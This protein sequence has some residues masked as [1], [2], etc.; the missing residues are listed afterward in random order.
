MTVLDSQT[1]RTINNLGL[2]AKKTK[3]GCRA[4]KNKQRTIRSII[5]TRKSNPEYQAISPADDRAGSL[6][7]GPF[8]SVS[9]SMHDNLIDVHQ[10]KNTRKYKRIPVKTRLASWNTR[11]M[12]NKVTV[13]CDIIVQD[14]LDVLAVQETWLSGNEKDNCALAEIART[15]PHFDF[16]QSPRISSRGG[17]VCVLAKKGFKMSTNKT[18]DYPSFE[19]MDINISRGS[20]TIRLFNIYRPPPSQKNKLTK[21]MFLDDFSKFLESTISIPCEILILGDFNVHFDV[22]DDR[23]ASAFRDL[24]DT[25]GLRQGV[26]EKTHKSGHILDLMI[27]RH[28]SNTI[29]G[30]V[31]VHPGTPS[32]H[33]A[34][35]CRLNLFPPRA[36]RKTIQYRKI[37]Q[38]VVDDFKRDIESSSVIANPSACDLDS[39][40]DQFNAVLQDLL[41]KHAPLVEKTVTVRHNTPWYNDELRSAKQEK[42]RAERKYM[43]S[44]LEVHKQIYADKC[45]HYKTMLES[46]KENHHRK[47][48]QESS[49]KEL[50]RAVKNLC[51]P[52]SEPVLPDCTSQKQL[53]EK[54]ATFFDEK[55]INIRTVIDSSETQN[56]PISGNTTC[57]TKFD[58]FRALSQEAVR[59]M[60]MKSPSKSCPL[61]PIPTDLFK[62]CVD[63]LLPAVTTIVNQSLSSGYIPSSLKSARVTPLLKKANSD[64]NVY[65]NYRPVSQLPFLGKLLERCCLSQ[66]QEHFIDNNL[67]PDAQSAYRSN[68]STETALLC[69]K[70]DILRGLDQNQEAAL[71]LL[72]LSA[73]FDT[74]DHQILLERLEKRYGIRSTALSWF[75]SYLS[76]RTQSVVIGGSVSNPRELVYG[77]P[78]G[79]VMGA[80]LFT[81]YSAPI[82]D[83]IKSHNINHIMY[84]DDTQ[85][86]LLFHPSE[87]E[88][89][90]NKIEKC[91][92]DI[93]TWAV[94]NKLQFND[95]K[96]EVLH[97]TSRF[98]D[99]DK[100][101]AV[102]IGNTDVTV[103]SK[104]RN[105]G[106]VFDEHLT[107]NDHISSVLRSGWACIYMLG[108]IR[109]YLDRAC[110]ERL[111]H[112]FITSRI[113][114]CNSLLSDLPSNQI[115]R[116]QRLQN[117]AARLIM[118]RK[119]RDHIT[120]ILADLH[121]LPVCQR[122]K[123]K[124]L[125]LVFKC[126]HGLGPSYLTCLIKPYIPTRTLRSSSKHLL[127]LPSVRPRTVTY[128]ARAFALYG[129]RLWNDL[130]MNI[131]STSSL[132]VFKNSLKT[133]LFS[134]YYIQLS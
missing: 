128:G 90:I 120:P 119:R 20:S 29:S 22:A 52:S 88:A 54:F 118:L 124:I 106:V 81:F 41:D 47:Q 109:R 26:T 19:Y 134:Q 3:R 7:F 103:C 37:R 4:G 17:G 91:I 66:V 39:L 44:Q 48:I 97:I 87:R 2:C 107:F 14:K 108:K 117:A 113:D 110:A 69:V 123:Y 83:V 6:H 1:W 49:T 104:A 94:A 28:A 102:K 60:I 79:S 129:P 133:F 84:A 95:K 5:T 58:G 64:K 100:L 8:S 27:S 125:L 132:N 131:R 85:L 99:S 74:I 67:Y 80:P 101:Q 42:R 68:H 23:F 105:L 35:N 51:N 116:L 75:Q 86:Y 36:P 25:A 111:V 76:N 126:F 24:L 53:A 32:D 31:R 10:R 9:G 121:W 15:L 78:Q 96:T 18:C 65:K 92:T 62:K 63:S 73:A 30:R 72:D 93:K 56:V 77:V 16:V 40:V 115:D 33:H 55:I 59:E 71:V 82:S 43:K 98:K 45:L 12:N 11:S 89:A 13:L 122:I 57:D 61:D 130:P 127:Q 50:F 112:A 38:I 21:S 70:N 114:S 34:V 46:A